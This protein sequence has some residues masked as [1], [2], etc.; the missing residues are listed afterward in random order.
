MKVKCK[1][2]R[3]ILIIFLLALILQPVISNSSFKYSSKS[4]INNYQEEISKLS[5]NQKN[6][7]LEK[8]KKYN[9][10]FKMF[11]NSVE[12]QNYNNILNVNEM[13]GYIEIEKISLMLPIYHGT[14][15]EILEKGVGHLEWT[16][17]PVGGKGTHSILTA[18]NGIEGKKL[19]DD[20]EKL[21]I[22]D[23]FSIHVLDSKLEYE[24][25][26]IDIIL[27]DDIDIIEINPDKDYVTL[28]TCT[29]YKINT[30]RLL[31]RGN[32][33]NQEEV[34]MNEK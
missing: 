6:N 14:S 15:E 12:M 8:A 33:I 19:F 25:D 29:P 9:N 30:H 31:V 7:E 21:E 34:L 10:E 4:I 1:Y 2:I 23:K 20:I 27:P 28:L 11:T 5:I 26:K 13:I 24:V 22:G 17:L 18:H 32:R 16:F 3:I